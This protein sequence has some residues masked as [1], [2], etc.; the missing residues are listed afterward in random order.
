MPRILDSFDSCAVSSPPNNDD[1]C[2]VVLIEYCYLKKQSTLF[3]CKPGDDDDKGWRKQRVEPEEGQCGNPHAAHLSYFQNVAS[4]NGDLYVVAACCESLLK[5]QFVIDDNGDASIKLLDLKLRRPNPNWADPYFVR[6]TLMSSSFLIQASP[7]ELMTVELY[8]GDQR[9]SAEGFEAGVRRIELYRANFEEEKWEHVEELPKDTAIFLGFHQ[10]NVVSYEVPSRQDLDRGG[11]VVRGNTVYFAPTGDGYIY[12][13]DV[14][15]R[16]IS[17][18]LASAK[19]YDDSEPIWMVP[20]GWPSS[21]TNPRRREVVAA[22]SRGRGGSESFPDEIG[23]DDEQIL[24]TD[25]S[26]SSSTTD[27]GRHWS[28]DIPVELLSDVQ[29]RLFGA[30]RCIFRLACRTWNSVFSGS[31]SASSNVSFVKA[32][33]SFPILIHIGKDAELANLFNPISNVTG[34]LSLDG[35]SLAGAVIHCCKHGWLLMS[36]G[37]R[38]GKLFFFNPFTKERIDLP[39]MLYEFEGIAFSSPPTSFDCVVVGYTVSQQYVTIACIHRGEHEWTRRELM[40]DGLVFRSSFST[41]V[42]HKGRLY[43]LGKD[44]RLCIHNFKQR[45]T[46]FTNSVARPPT[47]IRR[48]YLFEHNG[49]LLSVLIHH[50]GKHVKLYKL[51]RETMAWNELYDLEDRVLFLSSA[52]TLLTSNDEETISGLGNKMFLDRF[53]EKDGVFYSLATRKFH[54]L[55]SGYNSVDWCSTKEYMNRAWIEPNFEMHTKEELQWFDLAGHV[56]M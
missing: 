24:L 12:A 13:Y 50:M 32:T 27:D 52:S 1:R 46:K 14:E 42:Y 11:G 31:I 43:I 44:G 40:N 26:S 56:Y 23:S 34:I 45:R 6:T 51:N 29:S 10:D 15:E 28:H 35:S 47:L 48:S 9:D 30:D 17:V 37:G 36:R 19:G 18:W 38:A 4:F 53:K 2:I 16:S 20:H 41:P 7:T 21:T 22:N 55:W 54:T 49:K 33:D 5:V 25:N 39:S 8:Y 3:F